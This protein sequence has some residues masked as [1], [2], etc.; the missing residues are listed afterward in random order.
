MSDV[1]FEV[2]GSKLT[3]R[4]AAEKFAC[5]QWANPRAIVWG[6]DGRFRFNDG[7]RVYR[8]QMCQGGWQIVRTDEALDL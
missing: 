2:M 4:D 6:A 5:S 3:G 7:V 8:V 1:V